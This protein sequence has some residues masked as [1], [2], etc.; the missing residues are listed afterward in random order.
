MPLTHL[1]RHLFFSQGLIFE[2]KLSPS[3]SSVDDLPSIA[4][5]VNRT[6]H[7]VLE[8]PKVTAEQVAA[9]RLLLQDPGTALS[10]VKPPKGK[11]AENR[12]RSCLLALQLH[13]RLCCTGWAPRENVAVDFV[14]AVV[15]DLVRFWWTSTWKWDDEVGDGEAVECWKES[16]SLALKWPPRFETFLKEL[17]GLFV[18]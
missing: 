5:L 10:R 15:C 17:T 4:N 1:Q 14:W 9:F 2:L 3:L 8:T 16:V 18:R 13:L 11:K 6:E 12:L 7:Q